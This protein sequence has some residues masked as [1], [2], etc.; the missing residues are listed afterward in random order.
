MPKKENLLG[1]DAPEEKGL[2]INEEYKKRF[3]HNKRRE[4]K[5]HRT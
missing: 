3:E 5:Q 4:E 1:E 2:K